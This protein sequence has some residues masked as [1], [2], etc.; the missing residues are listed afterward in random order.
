VTNGRDAISTAADDLV[1][2]TLGYVP[3]DIAYSL[4][5]IVDNT[6]VFDILLI[7]Y[8][9]PKNQLSVKFGL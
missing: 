2:L 5:Q 7:E 3:K 9:Q 4:S 8:C 1:E 6:H